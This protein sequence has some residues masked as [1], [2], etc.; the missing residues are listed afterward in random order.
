MIHNPIFILSYRM[1]LTVGDKRRVEIIKRTSIY[2]EN[3][4]VTHEKNFIPYSRN[5]MRDQTIKPYIIK[6]KNARNH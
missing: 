2:F 3:V 1:I 5:E 6:E 4:F